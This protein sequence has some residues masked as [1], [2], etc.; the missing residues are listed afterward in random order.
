MQDILLSKLNSQQLEAVTH[1]SNREK[2][3]RISTKQFIQECIDVCELAGCP[4][5]L[6][7]AGIERD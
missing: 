7:I 3:E 4:I 1:V 5:D 2:T 6:K